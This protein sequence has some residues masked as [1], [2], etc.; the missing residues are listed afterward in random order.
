MDL[1]KR[2]WYKKRKKLN[3]VW[4]KKKRKEN[5]RKGKKIKEREGYDVFPLSRAQNQFK[6]IEY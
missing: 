6:K 2:A 1:L 4:K 5:K 3:K